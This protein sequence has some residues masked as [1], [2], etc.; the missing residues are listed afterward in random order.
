MLTHHLKQA[1]TIGQFQPQLAKWNHAVLAD[2]GGLLAL[3]R[4]W[5]LVGFVCY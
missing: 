1:T 2:D 3:A 5:C 4:L